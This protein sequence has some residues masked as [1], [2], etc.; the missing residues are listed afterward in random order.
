MKR[1]RRIFVTCYAASGAAALV[2]QVAWTRIFSLQLGHTTAA[3]STVLAAFMGGMAVGAWIGGQC[4]HRFRPATSPICM[5]P[6]NCFI[7]GIGDNSPRNAARPCADAH[8]GVHGWRNS[9]PLRVCARRDKSRAGGNSGRRN[10]GDVPHRGR[11]ARARDG[12]RERD[13]RI[14]AGGN[15]RRA[16]RR[17]YGRSR[18]RRDK[19]GLLVDSGDRPSRHDLDGDRLEYGGCDRRAVARAASDV[20]PRT[21]QHKPRQTARTTRQ[22]AVPRPALACAAAALSGFLSLVYKVTWTRLLAL[23]LG[24]TTYAFATMA[25]SF[26][27]GIA[28]GSYI[29][30]RLARRVS[31]SALWLGGML[32]VTAISAPAAAWF[33]ASRVPMFVASHVS[34]GAGFE[35]IVLQ[36][37]VAVVPSCSSHQHRPRRRLCSRSRHGDGRSRRGR[38]GHGARVRGKHHRR[39]RGRAVCRV[40]VDSAPGS[41]IE[42]RGNQQ[43]WCDRRHRGNGAGAASTHPQTRADRHVRTGCRGR[44]SLRRA[45]RLGPSAARERRIQIF[46]EP[47]FADARRNPPRG[48]ARVLQRGRGRNRQRPPNGRIARA[49]DRR[50]SRCV[51]RWRYADATPAWAASG[52]AP[53]Q[54]R[55]RPRHRPGQRRHRRLL[56]SHLAKSSVSMWSR[57]RPRS[58]KRPPYFERENRGV[59][60]KPG[61]RLLIG[62]G[63]S[64]LQLSTRQYDVIISEPSNP[65]DGRGR[66]AVH[67]RVLRG[68]AHTIAA[69]G[70][71]CQWAHSYE[72]R[73][74]DLQSIVRTFAAVFPDGTLW[75]VGDSDLLL[76]GTAADDIELRVAGIPERWRKGL[77]SGAAR[78]C[79]RGAECRTVRAALAV[80][81]RAR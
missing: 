27:T 28:F 68:R 56:F 30:T 54:S 7:A 70:V 12:A 5:R 37:A 1:D 59:L 39:G 53:R 80:R 3:S 23:V 36:E 78:R 4:P 18:H 44:C 10:G 41:A 74:Q 13:R 29:G 81:G 9:D 34:A 8:L 71:F 42:L 52:V 58:S 60:K 64:H 31:H 25:A 40:C 79:R 76:I 46:E 61:V 6:S 11:L 45:S 15:G 19:C 17:Q 66:R 75:L 65:V 20:E 49:G 16:L 51:K 72:N 14:H 67:P 63:R 35:S 73:E 38:T 62:D 50:Q 24:P 69:G 26:I 2:Y 57:S 33:A 32:V 77:G 43:G 48:K 22:T 21:R 47:G 55:R